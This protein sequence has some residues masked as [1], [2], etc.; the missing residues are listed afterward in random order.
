VPTFLKTCEV[1]G[2]KKLGANEFKNLVLNSH[3]DHAATVA[4]VAWEAAQNGPV[5][6]ITYKEESPKL[7]EEIEQ[8]LTQ[9]VNNEVK[10][11]VKKQAKAG[12]DAKEG[13]SDLREGVNCVQVLDRQ[14]QDVEIKVNKVTMKP[15]PGKRWHITLTDTFG[16]RGHDYKLQDKGANRAGGL[17]VIMTNIAP[18]RREWTQWK[19]RTARQDRNGQ[20]V[21]ILDEESELVKS[22]AS[23]PSCGTKGEKLGAL[24]EARDQG[25]GESLEKAK[26]SIEDAVPFH[27]L[28]QDFW[29][30]TPVM[31][32]NKT[33]PDGAAQTALRDLLG[34]RRES[35]IPKF[36]QRFSIKESAKDEAKTS[37]TEEDAKEKK[38]IMKEKA[39]K[40]LSKEEEED[41]K[42]ARRYEEILKGK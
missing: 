2:G 35:E 23:L 24:L 8:Q 4:G 36:R 22:C 26:Q 18:N 16:G 41:E 27:S 12:K 37:Q 13:G 14:D 7:M 5:L 40:K 11:E 10:R 9:K 39:K 21:V 19:G 31:Y 6:I 42:S 30:T 17:M 28:C 15:A 3:A 29:S 25:V 20:Y 32:N 34:N 33:W 1:D 38:R